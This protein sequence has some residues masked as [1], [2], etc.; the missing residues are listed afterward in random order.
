M[1]SYKKVAVI[2]MGL[3][4]LLG[5]YMNT[6]SQPPEKI[7]I[8]N[9]AVG[10]VQVVEKIYKTN[11]EWQKLL[12]PEQYNVTRLKGTEPPFTGR[13]VLPKKGQTGV[14]QCVGCGTDL[15]LV[16]TKFESG[17]GWPSFWDPV[18]DLNIKTEIDN[19][20]GSSRVEVLC[21]RCDAHLGH[22]FNDGPAPTGKRYCMNA[23]A[24]K[25]KEMD[26]VKKE[27]LEKAAF[28]AGCFWGTESIFKEV[29]G[30]VKTTVGYAGGNFKNPTYEDVCTGKTGHAE[31]LELEFD[32]AVVSY[33][34]LLNIFWQMH[35]P[36]T[37]NRQGPDVGSQY[38]SVIFYYTP[39]QEK[40]ALELKDKLAKSGMYKD[41]ISTQIVAAGDFYP[42]EE[43]HQ[44][45]NQK[46][47]LKP[48]CQ[49]PKR[50]L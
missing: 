33:D 38:R 28:A 4:F 42:A 44:D 31:T 11:Q 36:T 20:Y 26:L 45:Y 50:K 22:V 13:C 25:F 41:P 37:P 29:K 1:Y 5:T 46:N 21:A 17:T 49:I 40:L 3:G 2:L 39:Q 7:K 30:V 34:D 23:V 6:F 24:L 12:T 16:S 32:P 43:Y 18:S 19:S 47:G 9:A 14:Y 10:Q 48:H 27:K 35:D 15:F 8:F